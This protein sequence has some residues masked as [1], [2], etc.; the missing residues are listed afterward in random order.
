MTAEQ[1]KKAEALINDVKQIKQDA[2]GFN[3]AINIAACASKSPAH[4]GAHVLAKKIKEMIAEWETGHILKARKD[5]AE[6]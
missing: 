3:R 6:L 2:S 4:Y 5:Y 1:H